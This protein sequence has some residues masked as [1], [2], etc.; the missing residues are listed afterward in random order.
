MV[1]A[2]K[3]RVAEAVTAAVPAT[4]MAVTAAVPT[5]G[6]AAAAMTT[7]TMTATT[8]TTTTVTTTT[9]PA[10]FADRRARQQGRQNDDGNC[11]CAF[12]HGTLAAPPLMLR[13][14][15]DADRRQKFHCPPRTLPRSD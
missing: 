1:P 10:A 9:V 3:M 14:W 15:K 2:A 8:V 12:G 13:L 11:D 6:M 7:T 4:E 5:E